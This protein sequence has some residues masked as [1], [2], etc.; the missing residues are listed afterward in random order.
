MKI[1]DIFHKYSK[2]VGIVANNNSGYVDA[3]F[4]CLES[5]VIAVPLR[6]ENDEYRIKSAEVEEVITPTAEESWIEKKLNLH[7]SDELAL[8]SFTSG[9]EGNP[10]GV[11]LTHK[12]LANVVKRLNTIMEVDD[13]I[14]EYIGVPVYHSFGFGRCRAVASASGKIFVPSNGFNPSEIGEMLRKGEINAISAVPSLWRL[15]L[16]NKDLIGK[17][18]QKVRWIEIGSQYMSREEKE[19]MKALFPLAKIVQHYGLTEASRTTLLEVHKAEGELLE[20]VGQALG[21]IEVK[22]TAEEKIAIRGEHIAEKYIIDGKIFNIKDDNGWL[23]TNDLGLIKDGYLYYKGRADDV[24]NCGGIK[25]PPEA[26]ETKIYASIG[27]SN[28]LAICRKSDQLRGEGF[29]LA[30]TKEITVDK[31]K[32]RE[33]AIAAI[34]DF[35]VNAANA[36]TI[37][38][39]ESLPKTASGKIQR[40][41]LSEWYAKEKPESDE[42][43]HDEVVADTPIQAIFC[44]T[45]HLGQVNP[46]EDTF[47]SLGGDSLSYI[48]FSMKLERY[49]GYLPPK[50]EEMTIL[51]L[52]QEELEQRQTA[53]LETSILFRALAIS[54][55]VFNHSELIPSQYIQGGAFLLLMISGEN[56]ARFQGG[57]LLQGRFTNTISSLLGNLLIPY[58]FIALAYQIYTQE[59]NLPVLLLFSNF[60]DPGTASIFPIWFI[61]VLTQ[62][63]ILFS[64]L[65]GIRSIRNFANV[66]PWRFGL[67]TLMISIAIRLVVPYLWDTNY[68]FNRVP[69]MMIW[70]FIVGWCLQFAEAKD[71]KLAISIILMVIL[72]IFFSPTQSNFW[73]LLVGSMTVAWMP[74]IS[75]PKIMKNPVQIVSAAAYVI[76]LNHMIFIHIVTKVAGIETPWINATVALLGGIFVWWSVNL[77]QEWISK[78][79][80][81]KMS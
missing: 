77:L 6:D 51:E 23:I 7:D 39:V 28:G 58:L 36:I 63:I 75:V 48:Q 70:L 25:V 40:R 65:F 38:D 29:L 42:S 19:Q 41:K 35:G 2:R 27:Y 60:I 18:G 49:L 72:P 8:I 44:E 69:H 17:H 52:E 32:L 55:V 13:S 26:L 24:I 76:Y 74:Y 34:Q 4:A 12:N 22:L 47:I 3:M 37:I 50:W 46:E 20:S 43:P 57:S 54:G 64:L 81:H 59:F 33:V 73:W 62:C 56:F 67:I 78:I 14:R 9:T 21:E 61:Q 53:T 79:V 30:V 16:A 68:L 80:R 66:S 10:K 45:L 5:G 71:K 11:V 15:L 1:H 31:P